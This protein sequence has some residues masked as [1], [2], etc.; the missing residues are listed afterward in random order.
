MNLA[1]KEFK[2][3]KESQKAY[4]NQ[5]EN[6][7]YYTSLEYIDERGL[8]LRTYAKGN[9]S[10]YDGLQVYKGEALVADVEIPKGMKIAGYIEPYFYSEIIIDEDKETLS[11]LSFKLDGL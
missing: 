4:E 11:L 6:C 2:K 3:L 5:R 8:L 7:G 9:T 10:S 1:Y